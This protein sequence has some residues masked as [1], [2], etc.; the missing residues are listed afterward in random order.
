VV[1]AVLKVMVCKA[2]VTQSA[3]A[4][5]FMRLLDETM[6]LPLPSVCLAV[7]GCW[8]GDWAHS[9]VGAATSF[10]SIAGVSQG[11]LLGRQRTWSSSQHSAAQAA[12]ASAETI[13]VVLVT[14]LQVCWW[15]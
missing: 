6:L 15:E 9:A 12:A 8:G 5:T 7:C 1:S 3:V 10:S 4:A 14:F 13:S 2:S 11:C